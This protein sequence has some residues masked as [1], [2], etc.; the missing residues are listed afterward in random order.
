MPIRIPGLVLLG[1]VLA[2]PAVA[3]PVGAPFTLG[4]ALVRAR[5]ESPA[6]AAARARLDGAREASLMAGRFLNPFIELR[7]ENWPS[8]APGGLPLDAFAT[9]TQ[10]V[11]LGDKRGARRSVAAAAVGTAAAVEALAWREVARTVTADYLSA[12]RYRDEARAL[13]EHALSLAEATRV[14]GRRVDVGAAPEAEL[15]K[16]R[17]EEARAVVNRTRAEL[18]S[19]RALATLGAALGTDL[20]ADGLVRPALPAPPAVASVPPSHP[21]LVAADSVV[22]AARASLAFER[23]RSRPDVAVNAGVKRTSGFNT[24]VVAVTVPIP[25]FDRNGVARA[26]AG[27]QLRAAEQDREATARRLRG[28]LTAALAAAATLSGRAADAERLMVEPARGARDAARAAFAAGVLDVLRLVD[29][30]RV[31]IDAEL[32]TL[33]L[34]TDAVAAVIDARLAAGEEPLP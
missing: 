5:A 20:S 3:Q 29:A 18:A 22:D 7:S 32:V 24:G 28:T 34:E 15:L 19:A 13:A 1:A 31:F 26:I 6:L 27:G 21:E 33:Q 9:V 14:M 10:T 12:L 8:N 16:L 2:V 25:L 4:D 30:E 17:T 11:E 23:A